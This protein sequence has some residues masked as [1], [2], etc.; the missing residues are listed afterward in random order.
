MFFIGSQTYRVSAARINFAESRFIVNPQ[1]PY[2]ASLVWATPNFSALEKGVCLS[3]LETG[4][5]M[6]KIKVF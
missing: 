5:A 2:S 6:Q 1:Y 3:V 4:G